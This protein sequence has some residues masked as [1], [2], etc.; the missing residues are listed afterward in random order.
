MACRLRVVEFVSLTLCFGK[1]FLLIKTL[2]FFRCEFD[3]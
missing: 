2:R 1:H 3:L